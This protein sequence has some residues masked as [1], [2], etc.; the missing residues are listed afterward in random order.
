M[1]WTSDP[2]GRNRFGTPPQGRADYAFF[3]HILASMGPRSGRCAVLFPLGVL[4]RD[5]ER[6]MRT[7]VIEADLIDCVL[8]LGPG[9]FYNSPMEA[10]VLFCRSQKPPAHKG[11]ILFINAVDEYIR[12]RGQSFLA[13]ANIHRI[14]E[15]VRSFTP[16]EGFSAVVSIDELARAQGSLSIARW[17]PRGEGGGSAPSDTRAAVETWRKSG[18]RVRECLTSFSRAGDG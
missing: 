10:C 1:L 11:K 18:E 12:D 2:Y 9:L 6:A 14:Q 8:G 5:E 17:V 15:A 3:Q 16:D 7:R 13:D 4:F